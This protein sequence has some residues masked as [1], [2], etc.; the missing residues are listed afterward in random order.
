MR[1]EAADRIHSAIHLLRRVHEGDARAMGISPARASALS[2]LVFGGPRSLTALAQA[3]RVTPATMSRLVAAMEREG[4]VSRERDSDDARAV[5]LQATAKGRRI[6]ERGRAS[7]LDLLERLL[8]G[9]DEAEIAAVRTA[10]E[11]VE[12]A[13]QSG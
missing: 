2:V 11:V 3:E 7:R 9:A 5:R 8:A 4:L 10:A 13:L 12:R 6:L 1:R